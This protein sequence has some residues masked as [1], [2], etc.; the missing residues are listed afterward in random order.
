MAKDKNIQI[1]CLDCFN[2]NENEC[3]KNKKTCRDYS[4][5]LGEADG[6]VIYQHSENEMTKITTKNFLVNTLIVGVIIVILLAVG[7]YTGF[8]QDLIERFRFIVE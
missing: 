6:N 2:Y 1:R 3:R 8:L 7:W 5:I 4:R